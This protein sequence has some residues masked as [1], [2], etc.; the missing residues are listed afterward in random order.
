M[1]NYGITLEQ[2]EEMYN[3]QQG[4]CACCDRHES[5]F[6]R[7]LHV[8]HCHTTDQ[9]RGLLCTKCNPGIGYFDDNVESLEMAIAY[10]N[11]FKKLG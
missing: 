8:D 10:L 9:V 6:K 7:G 11:K 5:E 3:E 4:K 2:Y 1:K